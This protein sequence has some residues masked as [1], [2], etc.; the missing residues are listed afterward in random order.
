M[1]I[2]LIAH[3]PALALP[4]CIMH[5][6]ENSTPYIFMDHAFILDRAHLTMLPFP[7][8]LRS[9]SPSL[10]QYSWN[11]NIHLAWNRPPHPLQHTA[12]QVQGFS[13]I[14]KKSGNSCNPFFL[15]NSL[16]PYPTHLFLIQ[17]PSSLS[18]SLLLCTT[19]FFLPKL[20]LFQNFLPISL[21]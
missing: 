5:S 13:T 16:L 18:N 8:H 2:S 21:F 4:F 20:L 6:I 11:A 1:E 12:S 17:L 10:A 19:T 7:C 9:L 15:S 14:L 3:A